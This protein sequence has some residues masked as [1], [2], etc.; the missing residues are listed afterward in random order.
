MAQV[1]KAALSGLNNSSFPNN[2]TGYITPELLRTFNSDMIDST[3]NQTVYD[4]AS[5]AVNNSISALNT[6][7]SSQQPSFTAINAFTASQI[8]INAG[9]NG[10][11]QSAQLELDSLSAWTG[12]WEA[13]TSSI[14]EIR[15]GGIF[16]GYSTRLYFGNLLSASI[17][18]NV[19]GPIASINVLSDGTK[20]NTASFD[21]YVTGNNIFTASAKVSLTNINDFTASN[22]N[23]SLNAYTQSQNS[24][25]ASATASLS[26]LLALSSSLSGGYAT[27]GELDASASVLQAN[28]DSLA[29]SQ[30]VSNSYFATTGS[31]TFTGDQTLIDA[32]GN[33]ITLSD[34]SGSLMLVAKGFT[35]ASAHL[36]SSAAN[37]VN[38]IFK[39]NNNTGTTYISGSNNIFSNSDA[40]SAGFRRQLGANNVNLFPQLPQVSSSMA[41]YVNIDSNFI[42]ARNTS[43]MTMRG[44]VSASIWEIKGNVL[45]QQLNIGTSAANHAQGLTGGLFVNNC[46]IGA[47]LSI[48][49]NRS[50]TTQNTAVTNSNLAGAVTLNVNSSSI[51][52]S[53]NMT[54]GG[55]TTINNNTTGSARVTALNNAA[56]INSNYLGGNTTITL[57][58]SNDPNDTAD[59]DYNGSVIRSLIHGSG[60]SVR[61]N[62]GL[63]G[64]NTL[65]GTAIIGNGI[66]V[67]GSSQNPLTNSGT[68]LGSAFFGR[69]NA[70]NGNRALS[71][72]T[73]FAI[74]TGTSTSARKTGFLID[75]GSNTFV[76]GTLNISG[77]T[78]LTGSVY[79][80][81]EGLT[82]SSNT[83]SINLA[84]SNFFTLDLVSGSTTHIAATNI[85]KGQT[86]NILFT[87]PSVGTGSVSYNSTFKFPAGAN[88]VATP[89]T[90]ARD[91][92]TFVT[93]DSTNIYASSINNLG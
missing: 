73:I 21:S 53:N 77:S 49:A 32:G 68:N 22:G 62:T 1:S 89:I 58:G 51:M 29:S 61:V 15:N 17:V 80:N 69:Y 5:A 36:T 7:T 45:T 54:A 78:S 18:A 47:N 27:Q 63:T 84:V 34:T 39:D 28:I 30:A 8:L 24:F 9:V 12:S 6:F 88:Y 14:N 57:S 13:W 85:Q 86:I 50:N 23:T 41:D 20:L 64:S 93:F 43:P 38:I 71:A 33:T 44:P 11:T 42:T 46:Y 56:L 70:E 74:G 66:S 72:Q 76:E 16:Q 59:V 83:A 40:P 87:Q 25:N 4:S 26:E 48:V 82:I 31:N 81:V 67:T 55:T 37:K 19:G 52:Y 3:V 2:N 79:G 65:A 35:S 10:F 90:G 60:N 91:I 75:S 92:V